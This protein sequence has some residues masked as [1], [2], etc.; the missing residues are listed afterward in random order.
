MPYVAGDKH[1]RD[2]ELGIRKPQTPGE[3]NFVITKMCVDYLG[4]TPRYA[5]I[6]EVV[7]VLECAKLEA[8]RRI[9]QPYEDIACATNGDVYYPEY[10]GIDD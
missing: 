5:N 9:A 4:E 10:A 1:R 8:Y 3:L 6:N 2:L 7:G